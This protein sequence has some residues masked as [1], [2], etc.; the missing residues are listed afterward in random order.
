M[1]VNYGFERGKYGCFPGTIIAFP[2]TL[3]GDNPNDVDF[4]Q[5]LPAGFLRCDGSVLNG[6]DYPN[7]KDILGVGANSKFRKETQVLK[8][9]NAENASSGGTFQLPDLGAKSILASNASGVYTGDTVDD[10]NT[11]PKTIVPKVGIGAEVTLNQGTTLNINY[12]GQFTTPQWD[13]PF[14][15]NQ[16]W[17]TNMGVV[18]DNQVTQD[19]GFLMHSH[20]SNLPVY[21]Y[22]NTQDWSMN[23]S[24]SDASPEYPGIN[25]TGIIGQVTPIAGSQTDSKHQHTVQRSFPVRDNNNFDAH[26]NPWDSDGFNVVTEVKLQE[27]NTIKMDDIAPKYIIVEFFIKF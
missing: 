22:S 18:F 7:L 9:D 5:K 17:G 21:A 24:V 26:I 2:R 12:S 23:I 19:S 20:F 13:I 6:N 3:G 14:L 25:S 15:S 8:E 16:N 4:K 10:N 11:T 1:A 27:K